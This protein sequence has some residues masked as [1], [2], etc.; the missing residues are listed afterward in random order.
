MVQSLR[1]ETRDQDTQVQ[2][3]AQAAVSDL[4]VM[5]HSTRSL[6]ERTKNTGGPLFVCT[7]CM[8]LRDSPLPL[9]TK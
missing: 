5:Y 6:W 1:V 8:Q 9:R 2:F 3:Q 4:V 7:T